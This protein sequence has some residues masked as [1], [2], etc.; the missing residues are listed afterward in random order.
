M[1]KKLTLLLTCVVLVAAV[2]VGGT[3]AW[4]TN[5]KEVTNVVTLGNVKIDLTETGLERGQTTQDYGLVMPGQK[6]LKDPTVTNTSTTNACYVRVKAYVNVT[7]NPNEG[8]LTSLQALG[9]QLN[10]NWL[11]GDENYFYYTLPLQI[12]QS[13]QPFKVFTDEGSEVKYTILIDPEWDTAYADMNFEIPVTAEAIQIENG[14][15]EQ[16][17]PVTINADGTLTLLNRPLA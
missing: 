9:I 11:P 2:A 7:A 10:D 3:L 1:K 4:F 8:E 5:N 12:G 15:A 14:A 13:V 6:I 16:Q 17:W